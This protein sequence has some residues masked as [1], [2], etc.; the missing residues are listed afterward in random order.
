MVVAN[1]WDKINHIQR[2]LQQWQIGHW[3]LPMPKM[4]Y[5]IF[6]YFHIILKSFEGI[7]TYFYD[8][9]RVMWS[10]MISLAKKKKNPPKT[11]IKLDIWLIF[12]CNQIC[13]SKYLSFPNTFTPHPWVFPLFVIAQWD[14]LPKKTAET[15][16]TYKL[17]K[18]ALL[19]H[20]F[21][22]R[23]CL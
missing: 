10:L 22:N 11:S 19:P 15:I 9:V 14:D 7:F 8:N 3:K 20:H 5:F 21:S 1:L 16:L 17:C 4:W 2:R 23:L 18:I 6:F 13:L 12:S